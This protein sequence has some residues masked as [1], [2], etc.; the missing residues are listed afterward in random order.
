MEHNKIL[1][2]NV[3]TLIIIMIFFFF[4]L[5]GFGLIFQGDCT[6]DEEVQISVISSMI[7]ML[8]FCVWFLI[9]D[10]LTL[11]Y[12]SIFEFF[13]LFHHSVQPNKS[14][15]AVM[16]FRCSEKFFCLCILSTPVSPTL[17]KF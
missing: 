12:G 13:S 7:L 17:D 8:I 9:L 1:I 4:P 15:V 14:N 6:Y 5:I 10:Y 16:N 3:V 2:I 11:L